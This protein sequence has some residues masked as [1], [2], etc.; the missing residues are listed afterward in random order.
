MPLHLAGLGGGV[1][2][3][4][5]CQVRAAPSALIVTNA[6]AL[7]TRRGLHEL[8]QNFHDD[9]RQVVGVFSGRAV[10]VNCREHFLND[11]I[12]RPG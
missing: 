1:A 7:L 12:G 6:A 2:V 9:S 3:N 4:A 11:L 5:V 10:F 8:L